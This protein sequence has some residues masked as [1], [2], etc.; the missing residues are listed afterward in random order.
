ML[1][2]RL[3]SAWGAEP[4]PSGKVVW[5]EVPLGA[6]APLPFAD[7]MDRLGYRR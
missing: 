7:D 2:D 1:V 3:A 5:F 4:E 6:D